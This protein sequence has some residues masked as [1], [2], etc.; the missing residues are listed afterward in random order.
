MTVFNNEEK[1]TLILQSTEHSY[2]L[3]LSV[4]F[5]IERKVGNIFNG[6]QAKAMKETWT[7]Y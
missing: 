4:G 2:V 1:D 6:K 7:S 3:S 5:K